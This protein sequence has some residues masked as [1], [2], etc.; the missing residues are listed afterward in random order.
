MVGKVFVF[1]GMDYS[2]KSSVSRYCFEQL[3]EEHKV[4]SY[5]N[6]GGT[7]LGEKVRDIARIETENVEEQLLAYFLAIVSVKNQV[8]RDIKAGKIVLLDRWLL[9]TLVYQVKMLTSRT[10]QDAYSKLIYKHLQE[11]PVHILFF[12]LSFMEMLDRIKR[13]KKTDTVDR[14]DSSDIDY[15]LNVF[16]NYQKTVLELEKSFAAELTIVKS[17]PSLEL[18]QAKV[19]KLIEESLKK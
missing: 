11:L 7:I 15:K 17:E 19:L 6:P 1:E 16:N 13:I 12:D 10:K 8:L 14:F 18:L 4:E 3:K 2:G 9:S 5:R